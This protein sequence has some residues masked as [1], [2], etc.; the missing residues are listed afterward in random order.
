MCEECAHRTHFALGILTNTESHVLNILY[1]IAEAH[2]MDC[3]SDLEDAIEV[4]QAYT[5]LHQEIAE[6]IS[7]ELTEEQIDRVAL[8]FDLQLMNDAIGATLAQLQLATK[9]DLVSTAQREK[10]KKGILQA[11]EEMDE[12][13]ESPFNIPGLSDKSAEDLFHDGEED[14]S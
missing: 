11:M 12:G 2:D 7:E 5:N 9:L 14:D 1:Q 10:M 6:S 13:T 4:Y 8:D 3:T